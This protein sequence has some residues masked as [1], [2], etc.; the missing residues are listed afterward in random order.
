[1]GL[2]TIS[3]GGLLQEQEL[4]RER[5]ALPLDLFLAHEAHQVEVG[6][7]TVGRFDQQQGLPV[8][9]EQPVDGIL[10]QDD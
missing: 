1:M 4:Q 10:R 3:S 7:R 2:K 8:F 6:V 5:P 9:R